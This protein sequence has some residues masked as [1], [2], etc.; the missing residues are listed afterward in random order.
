MFSFLLLIKLSY[1]LSSNFY[2]CIHFVFNLFNDRQSIAF[3][4]V[5]GNLAAVIPTQF[6]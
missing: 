2:Q 3:K 1:Q 6:V 5:K 4:M